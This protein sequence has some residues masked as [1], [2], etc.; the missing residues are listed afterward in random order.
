VLLHELSHLLLGPPPSPGHRTTSS[1]CPRWSA[2]R[3][4]TQGGFRRTDTGQWEHL[5]V[6]ASD[7]RV[8]IDNNRI[9]SSIRNVA[10]GRANWL[11]CGNAEGGRRAA[12]MYTLI[13]SCKAAGVEPFAYLT[14]LLTRLPAATD[15]QIASFTPRAWAAARRS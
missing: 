2:H 1:S 13:E 6:F 8:E 5:T 3:S 15:S 11:A 4:V 12:V 7:G 9:E 10:V 14:D